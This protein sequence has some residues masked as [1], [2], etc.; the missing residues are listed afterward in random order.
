MTENSLV[1]QN[2]RV[3]NEELLKWFGEHVGEVAR[4][5]RCA[6][7]A[8]AVL[9]ELVLENE[10]ERALDRFTMYFPAACARRAQPA[11]YAS[12]VEHCTGELHMKLGGVMD[13]TLRLSPSTGGGTGSKLWSGGITLSTNQH[14][15]LY[16]SAHAELQACFS[17][18]G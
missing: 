15:I 9:L 11:D 13:V 5:L 7:P 12:L 8:D 17:Q 18:N 16:A 2:Y 4:C 1:I 10:I 14:L 3:S 6:E